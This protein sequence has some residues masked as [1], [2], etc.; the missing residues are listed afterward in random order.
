MIKIFLS[1]FDGTL[2]TNDILDIVCGITGKEEASKKIS[3]EFHAGKRHGVENTIIPRIN[4]LRNVTGRQIKN[5]LDEN[6]YLMEGAADL[7]KYL[8]Q[9]NIISVLHSGNILP[10]LEYYRNLLGI[11]YVLG[12]RPL[13]N[14]DTILGISKSQ[15]PT[16]KDF[17]LHWVKKLLNKL[18]IDPKDAIALGDAPV[19]RPIFELSGTSIAINPKHGIDKYA[20]YTVTSLMEIIPIIERLTQIH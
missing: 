16:D 19:D 17:K 8:R 2:V 10:V 4:F 6:P 18:H 15:F 9:K 14:N 1:D 11:D 12:N 5:K 3:E 7:F 20:T 13:M